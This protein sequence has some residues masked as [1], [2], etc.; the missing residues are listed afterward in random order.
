MGFFKSI[1][2]IVALFSIIGGIFAAFL[3]MDARHLEHKAEFELK[4]EMLDM[5]IRKDAE[6]INYYRTREI[7]QIDLNTAEQ[8]RYEYLQEEME[9][10]V[11]KKELIEQKLLEL[12]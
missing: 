2:Q 10:K 11:R 12:E 7:N 1:E 6:V 4:A 8:A 3:F 5:D 9:R